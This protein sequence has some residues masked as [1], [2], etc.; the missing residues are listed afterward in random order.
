[1]SIRPFTDKENRDWQDRM[2]G[3]VMPVPVG[4]FGVAAK[5]CGVGVTK[6]LP[7]KVDEA[8][9]RVSVAGG[10]LTEAAAIVGGARNT[11]HG[12][13]E[14]SF[15]VI[16]DL[17]NAYLNGRKRQGDITPFDVAQFMVLLKIGR[18]IQGIAVR[19]HFTDA[20]GYSAI[21]GELA[22]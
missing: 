5:A 1:M 13:K 6:L 19:D 16:A 4:Y 8:K 10:I 18:S 11:T 9:P 20:A 21:A 22:A 12:E 15:Q 17:W 7:P 14:R 2:M 3:R